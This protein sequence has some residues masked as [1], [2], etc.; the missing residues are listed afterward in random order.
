MFDEAIATP[1]VAIKVTYNSKYRNGVRIP[2]VNF[3]EKKQHDNLGTSVQINSRCQLPLLALS[4]PIS[5]FSISLCSIEIIDR[6]SALREHMFHS[7][8]LMIDNS[9]P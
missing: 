8:G 2:G 1:C 6:E 3:Q 9:C 7:N 4:P 5:F